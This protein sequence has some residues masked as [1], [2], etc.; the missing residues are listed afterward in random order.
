MDN[1]TNGT[2]NIT[3]DSITTDLYDT[4]EKASGE[5]RATSTQMMTCNITEL[6]KLFRNLDNSESS[7]CGRHLTISYIVG[8][9]LIV[10]LLIIVI[11]LAVTLCCQCM[12][13]T[14]Q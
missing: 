6:F 1:D 8:I 14:S 7:N 12:K 4:T 5:M 13:K 2:N 3:T 11:V 9:A 10:L